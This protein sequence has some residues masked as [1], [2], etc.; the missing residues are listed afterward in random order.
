LQRR[1][2][3]VTRVGVYAGEIRQRIFISAGS[4]LVFYGK[5]AIFVR[6]DHVYVQQESPREI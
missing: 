5:P 4:P 1:F 3:V 2:F 6:E